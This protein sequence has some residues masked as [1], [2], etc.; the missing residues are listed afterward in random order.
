MTY[1]RSFL[2][3]SLGVGLSV[4]ASAQ[5]AAPPSASTLP[6]DSRRAGG[7]AVL[8]ISTQVTAAHF[9]QQPVALVEHAGQRYA[10]VGLPLDLPVG[11]HSVSLYQ[12]ENSV[13]QRTI[14]VQ[15]YAYKSQ[16]LTIKDQSK[17]T[18]DAAQL[19]RYAREATEQKAAYRVFSPAITPNFPSFIKPTAGRY[20][21]P[22]GFKRFFNGA[23]RAP[24]AGIDIAAPTGQP[25]QAPATGTVIQTGDYFFNGQTVMIDHGQGMVSMLCHLSRIDVQIGDSLAQGQIIGL[26]G[27][28]GRATGAH[29]HWT[30]SLNDARVDPKLVLP[31]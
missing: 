30:L 5:I 9:Q 31:E 7:I 6:Q 25:V 12:P 24:H 4:F 2:F 27:A 19:E 8:A 16:H 21:S 18:P 14:V 1:A 13:E 28:T 11:E 3:G 26:V 22:F 29:L 15:D 17:V 23:P 20:S 10:V